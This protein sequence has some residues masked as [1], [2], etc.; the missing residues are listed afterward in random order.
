MC[1]FLEE[2]VHEIIS[3]GDD[4]RNPSACGGLR[5]CGRAV[6]RACRAAGACLILAD[7]PKPMDALAEFLL[8]RG[9]TDI[10]RADQP[11]MPADLTPFKAVFMYIHGKMS[12]KTEKA[13]VDYATGGGRLIILHHGIASARRANPEWLKLTGININPR[14]HPTH[15]WRVLSQTTHTLVN[16]NPGHYITTNG[17]EYEREVEYRSPDGRVK[18]GTYKAIDLRNTEVFL[19]QV[20][21]D[22]SA[23]TVL[24]GVRCTDPATGEVFMQDTGG[25]LKPAGKGWVIYLQPG[26]SESDF[27]HRA[28]L[29]I[30]LNCLTWTPPV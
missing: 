17:V 20:H 6:S 22:G 21:T 11:D 29:Q 7:E 26:H 1:A 12:P 9:C 23:K 5:L 16:I 3:G 13:L 2:T 28:Y 15:P 18:E 19:N 25:W 27:R 24:F 14:E 4:G 10:R 30:V 8:A